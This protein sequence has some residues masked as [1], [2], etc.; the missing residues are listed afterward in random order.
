MM[1]RSGESCRKLFK[2]LTILPCTSQYIFSLILFVT[3]NKIYFMRYSETYSIHN[4]HSNDLHLLQTNLAVYQKEVYYSHV[5]IFNNFPSDVKNTSHNPKSFKIILKYFF[6]THC[7]Y[8]I[9]EILFQMVQY[10]WQMVQFRF[11]FK[12]YFNFYSIF[13][14]NFIQFCISCFILLHK[15][16]SCVCVNF[17]DTY[18]CLLTLLIHI[19][20]C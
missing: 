9:G 18:N 17:T 14:S 2:E 1:G 15:F 11:S 5:R 7:L 6:I 8:T 20:V 3:N 16:I 19:I 4:R 13:N 10:K 12:F